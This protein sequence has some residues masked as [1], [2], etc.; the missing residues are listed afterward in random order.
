MVK[1]EYCINYDGTSC[2]CS[3]GKYYNKI[4]MNPKQNI[5]CNC[6]I[7]KGFAGA[8]SPAMDAEFFNMMGL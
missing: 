5:T 3:T 7:D 6:Y 8:M 1:C 2:T 4:I